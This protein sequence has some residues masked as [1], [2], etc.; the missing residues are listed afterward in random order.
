MKINLTKNQ[1]VI[2]SAGLIL[3]LVLTL[4]ALS[5]RKEQVGEPVA[6]RVWGFDD[7]P[8]MQE[9]LSAY[10]ALRPGVTVRYEPI[11]EEGYEQKLL[12]AMASGDSPD[13]FMVRGSDV[14]AFINKSSPAPTSSMNSSQLDTIFPT[15]ISQ[16][17]AG[18]SGE[19]WGLPVSL[20]SLALF[21]NKDDFEQAGI[22]FPPK[23]W[24][25]FDSQIALLTKKNDS[26]QIEHAGVALGGGAGSNS[27]GVDALL[28]LMMQN[29]AEMNDR[30]SGVSF[31]NDSNALQAFK[32]YLSF[33]NPSSLRYS[34]NDSL[35]DAV[36]LFAGG[37]VSVLLGY[38]STATLI[39]SKGPYLRYGQAFLPQ[40]SSKSINYAKTLGYMVSKQSR[41]QSYA[42]DFVMQVSM[43]EQIASAYMSSTNRP[44]ALKTLLDKK[45]NDPVAG[46]FALQGLTARSWKQPSG[47]NSTVRSLDKAI[48]DVSAGVVD[49]TTAL[50]RAQEE[51]NSYR[52]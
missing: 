11:A 15:A 38:Q 24:N 26:G 52:R 5:G 16:E 39:K 33:A 32:Y 29:G 21:Y 20:D 27:L 50:K 49:A 9:V 44:P 7:S 41:N 35:G 48:R 12:E 25:E 30:S 2:L 13:V 45:K 31:G 19:V 8:Q 10:Q 14:L 37:R 18:Y 43:Y 36:S 46:I 34:W 22:V 17:Y 51:I 1:I 47:Y 4:L 40:T 23:N 42:W 28:A 3:I 6:L